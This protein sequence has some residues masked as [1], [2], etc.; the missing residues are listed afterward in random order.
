MPFGG[1][2]ALI[3]ANHPNTTMF[4][5]DVRQT[6]KTDDGAYIQVF[7]TGSI[8]T[9]GEG[10]VRLTFETGTDKYYW[11]NT[12]IAIGII[13]LAGPNQL[14]IDAWMVST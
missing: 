4:T 10:W 7:E 3:D 8:Q 6:L 11:L 9:N 13:R 12:V 14:T 1:D 5:A 2:W